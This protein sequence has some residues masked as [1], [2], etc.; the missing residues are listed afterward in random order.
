MGG[1][2]GALH[3]VLAFAAGL[4]YCLLPPGFMEKLW[5]WFLPPNGG[6]DP[7]RLAARLL[8]DARRRVR[9]LS[10]VFGEL[11]GGYATPFDAPDERAVIGKM[12]ARLCR[13]CAGCSACWDGRDGRAGRLMCELVE[14][15]VAGESLGEKDELPPEIARRCRRAAQIPQRLGPLIRNF[16]EKRRSALARG[17]ASNLLGRQFRQAEV[18]LQSASGALAAPVKVDGALSRQAAAALDR[19]TSRPARCWR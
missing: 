3:P 2:Y 7:E 19:R 17:Q 16:G 12:R 11:A 4:V 15:A 9:A 13:G 6:H 18:L 5:S 1:D 14:R 8:T 10:A